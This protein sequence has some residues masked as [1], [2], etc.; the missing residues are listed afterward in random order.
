MLNLGLKKRAKHMRGKYILAEAK[1]KSLVRGLEAKTLNNFRSRENEPPQYKAPIEQI[2]DKETWKSYGAVSTPP[3]IVSFMLKLSGVKTWESLR[4]LEPGA[5][6]C[7][8]LEKIYQNHPNNYFYGVEANRD[9]Y[10]IAHSLFPQFHLILE[11]FLLWKPEIEFDLVIG[12]P[13]YGIIGDQSHYPIHILKKKKE[14]YKAIF[15]TWYGKYN[16][17]GAFIEKGINLLK[18]GGKLI[19]ILPTTFMVLDEFKL[20]RKFLAL[21]GKAIIYYLGPKI[22]QGRTVATVILICEKGSKGIELFEV[23]NLKEIIKC[24][25]RSDYEGG[26]IKFESN[27][28]RTFEKGKIALGEVFDIHFA[29]RSP[30]IKNHPKTSTR[31]GPG[32]VPALTG[33]NLHK[34]WIDYEKCFSGLYFPVSD[35]KLLRDFYGISHIVVGHTKAGKVVSAIDQKCYPWREELHLVPKSREL[36]LEKVAEY[37]NSEPV[38]EYMKN[39]YKEITPHLTMTQLKL[40]PIPFSFAK[41]GLL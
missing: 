3:E 21:S 24:Y 7:E 1:R 33:R 38:Q 31:A 25:E 23:K 29:A 30:E 20:L 32:L 4:I 34:G 8:F 12:N 5:G 6:L 16:I 10:D 27:D 39:L 37:L 18:N 40:L 17:Y 28:S 14:A 15:S 13:P 11:D 41:G 26:I 19:F 2:L 35:A 36:D 9:I 22:F